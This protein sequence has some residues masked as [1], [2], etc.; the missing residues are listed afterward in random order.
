MPA[1][2]PGTAPLPRRLSGADVLGS[3]TVPERIVIAAPHFPNH[4]MVSEP[5][6][7]LMPGAKGA[8]PSPQ[9]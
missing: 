9:Q 1:P 2:V 6:D 3:R 7:G 8:Y 5:I 4:D